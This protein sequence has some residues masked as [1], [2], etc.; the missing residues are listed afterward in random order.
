[1]TTLV[2]NGKKVKVS[3]DFLNLSPEDQNR[4]VEEIAQS[5]GVA[6]SPMKAGLAKLSDMTQNP[7]VMPATDGPATPRYA[8]GDPRNVATPV[9]PP[10]PYRGA[11]AGAD[12]LS[13]GLNEGIAALAGAPVDLLTGALNMGAKGVNYLAGTDIPQIENPLGGSDSIKSA[14]D[15]LISDVEPQTGGQ[16]YLR[17]IGREVGF[18]VPAA[19]TGAAIPGYGA[20]AREALKPYM[21]A[22]VASDVGAGL[23]GQTAREVAP[24]S[25]VADLIASLIGG[26]GTAF[27]A[28]RMTP[29]LAASPS[30]EEM[31]A[32]EGLAWDKVKSAPETM[33]DSTTVGLQGAVRAALPD[34]QLAAEAYPKAYG[35]AEKMGALKNPTIYDAEQARRMVGDRVAASPDE[36][37]VGVD[38][39]RAI[40][41]YLS[42]LKPSDL[43]G[44]AADETLDAL[45]T[46][47][48]TTH[49]IKKAEAVTNAGMKAETRAATTGTGGNEVNATRQNVRAIFDKERDLTLSGKRSGYT[50]DEM[51]AMEKLVMGSPGSNIARLLGRMAPSSGALPLTIF[52]GGGASGATAS[53]MTGN[54]YYAIPAIAGGVGELSKIAAEKM[55]KTQIAELL[56]TIRNGG[57]AVGP[58]AAR[59]ATVK[60][61]IQQLLG[62]AATAQ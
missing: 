39:K 34:S 49:Q 25:P 1:M 33:T 30:L 10:A 3:D 27:L 22:S 31:K 53:L 62:T 59:D 26:G 45:S 42:N 50:P 11:L 40:A 54:P 6:Q 56:A 46:A 41:D 28:S 13:S 24:D 2:I 44:G 43:Q 4:A 38:M 9:P 52:G 16:R 55:T 48:R 20:T 19:M 47:R 5:M 58:S 15:P 36:A 61:I 7:R 60:A 18:G 8:D 51:A 12:Q 14:L 23:A 35:M 37:R 57:K 17:R 21:A 29:R 32:R